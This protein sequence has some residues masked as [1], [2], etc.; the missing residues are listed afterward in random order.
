MNRILQINKTLLLAS[1]MLVGIL[2]AGCKSQPASFYVLS[3]LQHSAKKTCDVVLG[4]GPLTLPRY[5]EQPQLVTRLSRNQLHLNEFHRWA[6]PLKSNILRVLT[7]DLKTLLRARSVV[8]YPWPADANVGYEVQVTITQFDAAANGVSILSANWHLRN[9][10]N[11]LISHGEKTFR[12]RVRQ[13][14]SHAR[15]VAAMNNNL[16][17]LSRSIASDIRRHHC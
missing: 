8:P 5:L 12:T 15:V 10:D 7:R 14:P 6:E 17:A 16:N 4:V 13:K 11:K 3:P 2:L 9:K 1:I